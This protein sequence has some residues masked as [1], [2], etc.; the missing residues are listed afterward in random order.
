MSQC[1]SN[2]PGP[3]KGTPFHIS[4]GRTNS[5]RSRAARFATVAVATL[6]TLLATSV[7]ATATAAEWQRFDLDADNYYDVMGIDRDGSGRFEDIYFDLDDDGRWDTNM[8]NTRF[9]DSFLEVL[10]FDMDENEEVEAR[11]RDA[12]QREGFDYILVDRDQNGRWDSQ[13]GF[14]ARIIPGSNVDNVTR[15]NR[16]NA[17]S[18]LIYDFRQRTGMSLLYPSLPSGY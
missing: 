12:D 10:D 3:Q 9:S 13:G 1:S 11:L 7:T 6:L 17:S 2:R 18:T 14:V 16:Q 8:Y 4:R 5:T 15:S